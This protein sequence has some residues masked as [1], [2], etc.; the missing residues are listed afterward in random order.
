M[1]V[2]TSVKSPIHLCRNTKIE[3]DHVRHYYFSVSKNPEKGGAW[4]AISIASDREGRTVSLDV[5]AFSNMAAARR[6]CAAQVGRKSFRWAQGVLGY[7]EVTLT[8]KI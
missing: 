6:W 3:N 5:D 8:V 4:R 7:F 2:V 1:S